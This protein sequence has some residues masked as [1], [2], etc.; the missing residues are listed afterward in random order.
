MCCLQ[1]VVQ[2]SAGVATATCGACLFAESYRGPMDA[3]VLAWFDAVFDAHCAAAGLDSA[4]ARWSAFWVYA[5]GAVAA[6]LPCED[7]GAAAGVACGC[8][9]A[10]SS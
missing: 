8:D 9:A 5:G 4:S 10:V 7:C 1:V 6:G 2:E 3:S